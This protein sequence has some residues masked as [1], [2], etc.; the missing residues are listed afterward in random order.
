MKPTLIPL[1]LAAAAFVSVNAFSQ[2]LPYGAPISLDVAKKAA[3]AAS[4][5]MRK[6]KL[7]MTIAVVDSGG[8]LVYLERSNQA[9]LGTIEPAIGKAKAA[10]GIKAPTKLIEDLIVKQQLVNLIAVPGAFPVEGGVPLVLNNQVVGAIGASGGM[11]ADD[12]A[13][14]NAGA[15][16]LLP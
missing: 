3:Q 15:K 5:E 10:N 12:G 4:H 8:N 7:E 11:P 1:S 14:A 2:A 9:G 13:V 16:S 6:N